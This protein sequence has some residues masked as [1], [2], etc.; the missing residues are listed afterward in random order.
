MKDTAVILAAIS[1][2]SALLV[3]VYNAFTA[4]RDH[5][6]QEADRR[7]KAV[8]AKEE[9]ERLAQERKDDRERLA[10]EL[11]A[12]NKHLAAELK[13]A[14]EQLAAELR[15]TEQ[16][17]DRQREQNAAEQ[18]E[19]TRSIHRKLDENTAIT[20]ETQVALNENT[21]ISRQAFR[22]ANT[23]NLKIHSLGQ[24]IHEEQ[25]AVIEQ[26]A[27]IEKKTSDSPNAG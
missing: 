24:D 20:Q 12:T 7:Q 18:R 1:G 17:G 14:Q 6:W 4:A 5:R 15:Q 22:E 10:E 13:Q 27:A 8:D 26:L 2:L 21:E 3:M 25:L 9:R 16:R 19:A 11:V 23:V